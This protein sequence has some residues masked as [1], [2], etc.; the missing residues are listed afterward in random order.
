MAATLNSIYKSVNGLAWTSITNSP[1]NHLFSG[2]SYNGNVV[3][4]CTHYNNT[5]TTGD[6]IFRSTNN[7]LSFSSTR[8]SVPSAIGFRQVVYGNG[9]FVIV[10]GVNSC[11]FSINDGQSWTN[12][13]T[14]V[15]IGTV[16]FDGIKFVGGSGF[17]FYSSTNGDTWTL[18]ANVSSTNVQCLALY[19]ADN[20]YISANMTGSFI[21][22]TNG[23]N[24]WTLSNI[25]IPT[26]SGNFSRVGIAWNGNSFIVV[27]QSTGEVIINSNFSGSTTIT[28][29]GV[30]LAI[31]Y[32]YF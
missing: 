14:Q 25:T 7:G 2:L 19:Y 1:T 16:V 24:T 18:L 12:C 10:G 15:G 17:N 21:Y 27:G 31:K 3:I 20:K 6:N 30:N 26:T 22:S 9:V 23:G 32:K 29:S 8:Y 28:S 4:A 13:S 11:I 5:V